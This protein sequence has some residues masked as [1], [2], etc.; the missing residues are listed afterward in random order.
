[1]NQELSKEAQHYHKRII[2]DAEKSKLSIKINS[3]LIQKTSNNLELGAIV[4]RMMNDQ[5]ERAEDYI[6]YI[7][8]ISNAT[9]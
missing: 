7:R 9:N 1:M 2:D 8:N 4:R 6:N 3:E 5:I